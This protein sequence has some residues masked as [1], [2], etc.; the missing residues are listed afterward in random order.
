VLK[1]VKVVLS[2]LLMFLIVFCFVMVVNEKEWK[3]G[4]GGGFEGV[5]CLT[6]SLRLELL[7]VNGVM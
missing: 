1:R 7:I 2:K 6:F 4:L 5:F 3:L